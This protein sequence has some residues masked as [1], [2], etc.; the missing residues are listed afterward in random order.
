MEVITYSLRD[1]RTWSDQYYRDVAAFTDEVLTET[2]NRALPLIEAFLSYLQ[3]TEREPLRTRPEYILELL[4]LG[5]LWRVHAGDAL[6]L[7]PMPRRV[8]TS[9]VRLRQKGGHLKSGIDFL[10]GVLG[11]SSEPEADNKSG[12]DGADRNG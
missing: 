11:L 5:V 1:S 8:L 12:G 9:L 6:G 3:E 2:E 10:H 7:A 4:T